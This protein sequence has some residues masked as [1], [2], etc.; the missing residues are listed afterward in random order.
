MKPDTTWTLK[1]TTK[2]VR[3]K[4]TLPNGRSW[5]FSQ[6]VR[7][8]GWVLY[9]VKDDGRWLERHFATEAKARAYAG[10]RGKVVKMEAV[11]LPT[12]EEFR[13]SL[14]REEAS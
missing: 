6:S 1:P 8:K 7:G 3:F 13:A 5:T 10:L 11:E 4:T 12:E 14:A 2:R 9:G